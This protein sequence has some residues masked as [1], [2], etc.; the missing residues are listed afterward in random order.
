MLDLKMMITRKDRRGEVYSRCG[1]S[2]DAMPH[3]SMAE[4][5]REN[6]HL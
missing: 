4:R 1:I 3:T 6:R 2:V 5:T